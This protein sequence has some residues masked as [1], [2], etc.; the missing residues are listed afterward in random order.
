M[1]QRRQ[2][3]TFLRVMG[4][5]RSAVALNED[6]EVKSRVPLWKLKP[7]RS[8]FASY[9]VF[10]WVFHLPEII[11]Y[12]RQVFCSTQKIIID[13]RRQPISRARRVKRILMAHVPI[14]LV[15]TD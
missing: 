6:S 5:K 9:Q 12:L 15:C 7:K 14:L 3:G 10:M 1:V 2:D 13:Q 4:R 8:S 11:N